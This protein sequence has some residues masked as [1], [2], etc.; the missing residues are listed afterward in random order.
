MPSISKKIDIASSVAEAW[1]VL[2]SFE[3]ISDW[4]DNVSHSCLLSNQLEGVGTCRRI[5][6]GNSS[7]TEHVTRW[8]DLRYLS[9]EIRGLPPVFKQ[10]L[11][12]W[13]LKPSEIGVQLSLT[14]EIIP[15][16][17]P[18]TPIAGLACLAF[19]RVNT[20]MLKDLKRF[21][22][23]VKPLMELKNQ[24]SLLEQKVEELESQ[25]E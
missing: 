22:E 24:I 6:T 25:N 16:R 15:I 4:A 9:Y 2:A 14:I 20:G 18:A 17:R 19:G 13:S 12:T 3:S 11:N 1:E 10:V 5:Q 7:V 8:E 21:I 23:D